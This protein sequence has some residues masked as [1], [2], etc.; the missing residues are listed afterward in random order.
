MQAGKAADTYGLSKGND[1]QRA[2]AKQAH[3]QSK[4]EGI[5][6]WKSLSRHEWPSARRD[7][8]SPACLLILS[9]YGHVDSGRRLFLIVYVDDFNLSVTRENLEKRLAPL[10][11]GLRRLP[12]GR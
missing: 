6:T 1:I 12:Q 10:G 7:N 8:R 4:L 11:R 9:L 5:P 3:T 2:E